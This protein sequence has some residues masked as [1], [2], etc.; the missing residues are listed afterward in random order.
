[1]NLKYNLP[2]WS[3]YAPLLGVMLAAGWLLPNHYPPWSTFHSS[4]WVAAGLILVAC[5]RLSLDAA[6]VAVSTPTLFLAVVALIPWLQYSIG[7]VPLPSAALMGSMY[8]LGL[9]ASFAFGE[10]WQRAQPG[11]PAAMMLVAASAASLVS[12]GLQIYQWL[13]FARDLDLLDIWVFPSTGDRPFANL[14]QP[15]LLASL[16]LWGLLGIAFAWHKGWLGR[17]S[18]AGLAGTILFGVALTESRT[19]LVTLTLGVLA[20]SLLRFDF[21][22]RKVVRGVQAAYFLYLLCLAGLEPLGRLLGRE[23]AATLLERSAGEIRLSLWQMALDAASHRPWLGFGW[24]QSNDG[25]LL[26][27]PAYPHLA[28]RYFEHSH[29]LALDLLVWAGAPLALVLLIACALWLRRV[30][31]SASDL[32]Q[33]LTVAALGV[34]LVHAMLEMPLHQGYFL[35]PFGVLA[36][37]ATARIAPTS[38]ASIPRRTAAVAIFGLAAVLAA[39]VH[40]YLRV[41]AAFSELRFELQ[42]IGRDH[43]QRP[44]PTLLLTD[45]ADFIA[46]SR[47]MP[48]AGM[49]EAQIKNWKDLLVYNSSPLAF[50]KVVGALALNGHVQEARFW[51]ERS[52]ALLHSSLCNRFVSEWLSAVP[53]AAPPST[54]PR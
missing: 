10:H 18:A 24:N 19:A 40:D 30:A 15:N 28:N 33:L 50:R 12:V 52:C 41:E 47:D 20:V 6:P 14:G 26:V 38:I 43:D 8:L 31:R 35:W 13:G 9:A 29:N 17:R 37:A 21:L 16:L 39:L 42:H 54:A 45:W 1:M 3:L 53:A 32:P 27:F 22:E 5:W 51:D 25:F 48:R 4:A 36:G 49:S 46:M 34:M 23:G 7:L 44:P 11:A 2:G